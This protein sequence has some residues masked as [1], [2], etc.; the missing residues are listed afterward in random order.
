MTSAAY[1]QKQQY[2]GVNSLQFVAIG[3]AKKD[4]T[5]QAL[6]GKTLH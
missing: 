5:H 6:D 3:V 4:T 2:Q 1:H